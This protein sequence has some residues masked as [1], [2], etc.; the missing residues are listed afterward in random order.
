MLCHCSRIVGFWS[1]VLF[2]EHSEGTRYDRYIKLSLLA[3]LFSTGFYFTTTRPASDSSN[4]VVK[5][6]VRPV[7]IITEFDVETK[8]QIRRLLWISC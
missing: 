4:C 5:Y 3:I 8:W 2:L 6:G 1:T 7:K